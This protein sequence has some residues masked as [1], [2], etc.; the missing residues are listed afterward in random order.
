MVGFLR[1][2]CGCPPHSAI[3]A[4][5]D[6]LGESGPKSNCIKNKGRGI[7]NNPTGYCFAVPIFQRL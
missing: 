1:K 4:A 7:F 3:R 2:G 5:L 6:L